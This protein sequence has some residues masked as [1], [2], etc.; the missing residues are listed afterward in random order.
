MSNKKLVFM[1]KLSVANSCTT[2]GTNE[3][4]PCVFYIRKFTLQNQCRDRSLFF[5]LKNSPNY[6]SG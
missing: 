5:G 4:T 3:Y 2:V 6:T 1:A